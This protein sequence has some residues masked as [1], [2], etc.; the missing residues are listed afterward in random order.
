MGAQRASASA[1]VFVFLALVASADRARAQES[2]PGEAAPV[3]SRSALPE[4]IFG[5][6]AGPPAGLTLGYEQAFKATFADYPGHLEIDRE[7]LTAW[8]AVGADPV[9][10][11]LEF[12]AEV[13]NYHFFD[14]R[15]LLPGTDDP[16]PETL[17]QLQGATKI[18]AL[19]DPFTLYVAPSLMFAGALDAPFGKSLRYGLDVALRYEVSPDLKLTW[20][21]GTITRLEAHPL[22]YPILGIE[23]GRFSIDLQGATLK[24]K[25]AAIPDVLDVRTGLWVDVRDYRLPHGVPNG[26]G[27][28]HD[29]D[30]RLTI[31]FAWKP[32]RGVEI[33]LDVGSVVYRNLL[34][35]DHVGNVVT[36]AHTNP[37]GFLGLQLVIQ[38]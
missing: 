21:V 19:I 27:V 33:D 12:D 23:F 30:T 14:V 4:G 32:V 34:L 7:L 9:F 10:V 13:S 17:C 31:G 29:T 18:Y 37:A 38:L 35:D 26:D 2:P 24:A 28:L 20:G 6:H 22:F 5:K 1:G 16:V 15:G 11:K 36:R 25:F 8:T 3:T